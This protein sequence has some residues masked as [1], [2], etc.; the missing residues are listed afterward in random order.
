MARQYEMDMTKGSVLGKLLV[1]TIPLMLSGLLQLLFNAA[2]IIVVGRFA[3]DNSLAAVGSNTAL[4]NLLTNL[5]IGLSVGANVVAARA[6]GAGNNEVLSKTVHTSVLLGFFSGLLLT[7]VG[8]IFAPQLL[9]IMQTPENV[10]PLAVIYIRVYFLGMPAMMV[11]NFGAALLR[12]V[13]DTRRPMYCLIIAGVINVLLNLLFVIALKMDVA[14]VALATA[15]AQYI[16]AGLVML[17]LVNEHGAIQFRFKGLCFDM[18]QF[19]EILKIGLPAGFQGVVF[20]LSNVV[21]Q[22]SI[23]VFG[24]IAVAGNSAA[25]SIEGFIYMAMNS[26]YQAAISFVGQNFGAKRLERIPRILFCAEGCVI[27]TGLVFGWAAYLL[28]EPLLGIY[29][30]NP[31]VVAAGLRRMSVI[32]T[33]YAL[34]GMMDVMVGVLRGL[35]CSVTPMIVSLAGACG[36][37]ILW[38]ATVFQIDKYHN[39]FTVYISYPI[40]WIITFAAHVI[41]FLIVWHR[42]KKRYGKAET[43]TIQSEET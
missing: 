41:C 1:F 32:A 33:T 7:A 28:G 42:I 27:T 31:E 11:Y 39:I 20:A 43:L 34:C 29:T 22:S 24:E 18:R 16:S 35:G 9:V 25:Q 12:S 30:N 6:H 2:D 36:L 37:R 4:I 26:F 5:F 8:V 19:G 14:G 38:I 23:N 13:G 15:I 17:C 10:L 3:G 40:T 21:I